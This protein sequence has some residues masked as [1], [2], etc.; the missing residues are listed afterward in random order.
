MSKFDI[1][2]FSEYFVSMM[3][4]NLAAKIAEISAEKNDTIVIEPPKDKHFIHTINDQA[5]NFDPFIHYGFSNISAVGNGIA[6][7]YT[8]TMF[9]AFYFIDTGKGD[10]A[11]KKLLRYT[12]AMTEIATSKSTE[13]SMIS[14][15]EVVPLPPALV[16]LSEQDGAELKVGG[17]EIT[18]SFVA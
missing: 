10:I 17:I 11:E 16:A 2:G 14:A 1:E 5:L 8:P 7:K 18:G 3:K 9:F 13:N 15:L 6:V 12:R 4:T